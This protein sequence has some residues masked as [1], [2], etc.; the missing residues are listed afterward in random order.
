MR[1]F[2][3]QTLGLACAALLLAAA[4]AFSQSSGLGGGSY[5]S[6][7]SSGGLGSGGLSSGGFGGSSLGSS[8]LGSGGSSGMG[9]SGF[10][11]STTGGSSSGFGTTGAGTSGALGAGRAGSTQV[12]A[13]SFEGPYYINPYSLGLASGTSGTTGATSGNFGSPLYNLSTLTTGTASIN[14]SSQN[15]MANGF[16]VGVNIRRLPAY[17]TTLKF[18]V[19]PPPPPAQVRADLQNML[20]QTTA[21][22]PRRFRPHHHGRPGRGPPRAGRG[23]RRTPVGGEHDAPLT[24]RQPGPQRTCGGNA[25]A[26]KRIGRQFNLLFMVRMTLSG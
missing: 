23:R 24:R 18:A 8:G 14:S 26:L 1:R 17:A 5:G 25:G 9:S 2:D 21:A 7:S 13:T 16:G 20:A 10:G 15:A 12:G 6:G 19:P 3:V 4:P 22:E 11:F